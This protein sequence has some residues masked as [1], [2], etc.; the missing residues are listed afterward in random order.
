MTTNQNRS[1]CEQPLVRIVDDDT[2]LRESLCFMLECEGYATAAYPSA[3]AFLANDMPSRI[4][5]VVLD[6]MMPD[7]TGL[8]LQNEL[9]RRNY[10]CPII[11]LTAHGTIDMAVETM[12]IGACDFQQKPI[13]AES[14][15][16]AV[17]R[18][19]ET[20]RSRRG[21]ARDIHEERVRYDKLTP[22]E[23]EISRLVAQGFINKVIAERLG[24]SKRTVDHIRAA[25]LGKLGLQTI[26][27]L[28][29]F[30]ER[31]DSSKAN[32]N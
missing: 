17:A 31:I 1:I 5:C 12:R 11:F 15:L 18:A 8:E 23:E 22:R 7:M 14:F 16:Q 20:D 29:G 3:A 10:P 32:E 9:N 13:R 6:V 19:V 2:E 24:I 30:F 4:G 27:E 21:G 26:A 25:A 28:A